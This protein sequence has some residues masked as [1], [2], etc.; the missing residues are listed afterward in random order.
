MLKT[1]R[2]QQGSVTRSSDRRYWVVKYR[3]G[4]QHKTKILGKVKEMSKSEAREKAVNV[5]KPVN[6][7]AGPVS[8]IT[9]KYF[10]ENHF[11][12]FYRKHVWKRLTDQ[13][14]TDSIQ[15][16]IVGPLGARILSEMTREEMQALL[17]ERKHLSYSFV[18]HLRWDLKQIFSLAVTDGA[19]ESSPIYADG[20]LFLFVPKECKK[21]ARPAMTF[22]QAKLAFSILDLR[23]RLILKLGVLS[24][25]RQSEI[26]GLRRGTI[27]ADHAQ[28]V[29]RVCRRDI[30][31]PKTEKSKRKAALSSGIQ[32]DMLAWLAIAPDHG[33]AGWLFPSENPK[34]PMG[35]DNVMSRYIRPKLKAIGLGWVDYR[36]LRRTHSSLMKEKGVDPKLVADQQGHGLDVNQNVYTQTSLESRLEAVEVLASAFVN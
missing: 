14:R 20:K 3:I 10:V 26:F 33:P 5:M 7:G 6:E 23:E 36:V 13:S 35:A 4:D 21:P 12:P 28:I 32:E 30:D 1:K 11:L 9:L 25:M 2:F 16:H 18:D 29:E 15:L 34:M 31:T 17:D 22:D 8:Q 24:G 19:I 27:G